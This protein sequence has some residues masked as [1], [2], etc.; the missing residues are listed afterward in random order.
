MFC[1]VHLKG[2]LQTTLNIYVSVEC[3]NWCRYGLQIGILVATH[4]V[5]KLIIINCCLMMARVCVCVGLIS[6]LTLPGPLSGLSCVMS[7]GCTVFKN[8]HV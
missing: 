5:P 6:G 2:I 3:V 8:M 4:V 1:Y 7:R